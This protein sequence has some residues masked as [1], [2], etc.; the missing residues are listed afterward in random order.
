MPVQAAE[1]NQQQPK[2]VEE[3]EK[4]I[5]DLRQGIEIYYD[6]QI[7]E[8][9][10]RGAAEIEQLEEPVRQS[11]YSNLV[12]QKEVDKAVLHINGIDNYCYRD[13]QGYRHDDLAYRDYHASW[14]LEHEMEDML[15]LKVGF[16][17]IKQSEWFAVVQSLI[18]ERKSD[19][20]AKMVFET[21]DLERQKN[22]ALTVTLPGLEKQLKDNS[23]KPEPKP[24]HGLVTGIV[25]SAKKPCA[26]VGGKIVH[27][28][29]VVDGVTVVKISRNSVKF[30]KKS[31]TWEQKVQQPP[32]SYW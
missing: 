26:A 24:A 32:A 29:D 18:A 22:Y 13:Y 19:I 8:V 23:Q 21:A 4:Y 2:Q 25:Y 11:I 1:Q 10:Q 14:Y 9:Q 17:K 16:D 5:A 20:L 7:I 6:N 3:I 30:S 15:Q 28:R 31:K 12:A 27:N